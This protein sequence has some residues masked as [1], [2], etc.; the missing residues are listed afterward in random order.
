MLIATCLNPCASCLSISDLLACR[1]KASSQPRALDARVLSC[2]PLA[3]RRRLL[4]WQQLR[5]LLG[6]KE[7]SSE[8]L[9]RHMKLQDFA[10]VCRNRAYMWRSVAAW[11]I[12]F[13]A[14]YRASLP[15]CSRLCRSGHA[16][17]QAEGPLNATG[18]EVDGRNR[19]LA[20]VCVVA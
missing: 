9:R 6:P 19:S 8:N 16:L 13:S 2:V 7:L 20:A 11:Q 12:S 14:S 4:C 18:G 17:V 1:T 3:A 15:K 5:T 10:T